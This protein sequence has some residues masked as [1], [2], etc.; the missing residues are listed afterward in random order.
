MNDVYTIGHS[1]RT[2]SEFLGILQSYRIETVADVR[3]I[4]R[5]KRN[6]Q[7]NDDRLAAS[8]NEAEL[9]YQSF[10]ELGGLRKPP[11]DS[12]NLGWRNESFRGYADYMQT[13]QFEIGIQRLL[14]LIETTRVSIM[15][16]EAVPWRCHRSLVADALVVRGLVVTDIL[17]VK[18]SSPHILTRWAKVSGTEI[19][20]PS[21]DATLTSGDQI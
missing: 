3:T 19:T 9:S 5:S 20:Y 18:H 6:P 17:D 1:T 10:R 13:E 11:K 12:L 14:Q 15:C 7:F 16:A 21:P 8:L 4:P 2:I